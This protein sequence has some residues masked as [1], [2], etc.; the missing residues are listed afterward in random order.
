MFQSV[1]LLEHSIQKLFFLI[2]MSANKSTYAF[3]LDLLASNMTIIC[4]LLTIFLWTNEGRITLRVCTYCN[5]RIASNTSPLDCLLF[6]LREHLVLWCSWKQKTCS[7]YKFN[8]FGG[9]LFGLANMLA[10]FK[11][12]N[13]FEHRRNVFSSGLAAE[14]EDELKIELLDIFAEVPKRRILS[15]LVN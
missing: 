7:L 1:N 12:E 9:D 3:N 6:R 11:E 8:F 2:N 15:Q 10:L 13:E 4:T 5:Q 14:V